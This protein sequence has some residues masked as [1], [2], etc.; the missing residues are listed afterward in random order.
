MHTEQKH[1]FKVLFSELAVL[2]KWSIQAVL[3]GLV[4]EKGQC[5]QI[6]T[7]RIGTNKLL[8]DSQWRGRQ[9][10]TGEDKPPFTYT[11][12]NFCASG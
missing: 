8:T 3:R 5:W 10:G 6:E 12:G 4:G 1:L 2:H 9:E 11:C 7:E